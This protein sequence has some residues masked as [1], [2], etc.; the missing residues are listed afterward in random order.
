MKLNSITDVNISKK[1]SAITKGFA[2]LMMFF[3]HLFYS[4]ERMAEYGFNALIF[5][6]D[7]T[8][9]IALDMKVCV[10]AFAFMSGYGMYKKME[11]VEKDLTEGKKRIK[12]HSKNCIVTYLKLIKDTVFLILITVPLSIMLG[13]KKQP[14]AIWGGEAV[15]MIKGIL[16]NM[17]G[18]ADRFDTAW[19]ISSWWYLDIAIMFIL[20]FPFIYEVFKRRYGRYIIVGLYILAVVFIPSVD[21]IDDSLFR[22]LPPFLLGMDTAD[23]DIFEKTEK[24]IKEADERTFFLAAG[25]ILCFILSVIV[26]H[27]TRIEFIPQC[28]QAFLIAL[29]SF[30]LVRRLAVISGIMTIV[31][32][33]S[34]YMWLIHVYIYGQLLRGFLFSMKNIWLI[35]FVLVIIS[36]ALSYVL[37]KSCDSLSEWGKSLLKKV[38]GSGENKETE[39][40]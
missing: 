7:V 11:R 3:H 5:N 40:A 24:W 19:F 9:Q 21:V 27:K 4:T 18:L 28:F 33:H 1:G 23:R 16:L 10:A 26:Q 6:R 12:W 34:K 35:F 2:L 29:F 20:L 30:A 13:L 14:S 25:I 38:F 8:S 15:G 39:G 17:T 36:L 37:G 22:Y 31:G 32:K